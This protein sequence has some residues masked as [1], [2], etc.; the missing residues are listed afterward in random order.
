MEEKNNNLEN[1]IRRQVPIN[2]GGMFI[3]STVIIDSARDLLFLEEPELMQLNLQ[4][5][6]EEDF[7]DDLALDCINKII[8]KSEHN[9]VL[10]AFNTKSFNDVYHPGSIFVGSSILTMKNDETKDMFLMRVLG[11]IKSLNI[12]LDG[13]KILDTISS[14]SD[15][16]TEDLDF[17][18][19]EPSYVTMVIIS[20]IYTF[21]S[22][23][24]F[25]GETDEIREAFLAGSSDGVKIA[26]DEANDLV[27]IALYKL[28]VRK[29]FTKNFLSFLDDFRGTIT[30]LSNEPERELWEQRFNKFVTRKINEEEEE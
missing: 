19:E 7:W 3:P 12:K 28:Y 17:N 14:D 2:F 6:V 16:I 29:K 26:L 8:K 11:Y 1:F 23:P 18:A 9:K 25:D 10:Q 27:N 21:Y 15:T 30:S 22:P 20:E 13:K 5:E 4:E 24:T